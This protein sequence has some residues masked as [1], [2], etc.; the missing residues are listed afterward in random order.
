MDG[1]GFRFSRSAVA[2][3]ASLLSLQLRLNGQ[4]GW[5]PALRKPTESLPR[6]L[7]PTGW[8]FALPGVEAAS[9]RFQKKAAG[10]R[11]HFA[12]WQPALRHWRRRVVRSR[13]MDAGCCAIFRAARG[14]FCARCQQKF[15]CLPRRSACRRRLR[16]RRR[17]AARR[18]AGRRR[19]V[20]GIRAPCARYPRLNTVS[21]TWSFSGY[22]ARPRIKKS[23]PSAAWRTSVMRTAW[24]SCSVR[25]PE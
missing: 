9:C 19:R 24:E 5:Q 11:F 25:R 3:A 8:Q 7:V 14:L 10:R 15:P 22:T 21:S 2:Q 12:G 6:L 20:V 13:Q 4:A 16:A 23:S 1:L 17:F 18:A